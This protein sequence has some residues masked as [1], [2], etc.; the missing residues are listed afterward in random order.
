MTL[1]SRD[2]LRRLGVGE[3]IAAICKDTGWTRPQF[4]AWW[5][6]ECRRRLPTVEGTASSRGLARPVRICRD[7]WGVPHVEAHDDADLFFGFG[8]ATAQDRLFQLDF[9]RRKALGRLAEILGPE[10]VE[11]DL[12]YRTIGLPRIA[13]AEWEALPQEVRK[14]LDSYTAGVNAYISAAADRLPIEFDLLDY[15]PEPWSP[16]DSLAIAGEFRWYLT[17]RFPVIAIPEFVKRAVG[18]GPLYRAFLQGEAD[19]E[20]MMPPGSYTPGRKSGPQA[21]GGDEHGGSN[22]WV[23]APGLTTTGNAIVANDPHVP[24]AAVS[25]WHEIVLHGGSFHVGG[26]AYAGTPAV[27]IGRNPQVAWG[28]TNNICSLRD[29][30]ME[31]TDPQHPDH[32]LFDGRWEPAVKREEVIQVRDG[33]DVVKTICSSR[34]GPIVD[35]VL[36]GPAR[37]QGPVS[38]R[39]LGAEPCGWITAMLGMNRAKSTAEFRQATRPWLVPTFNLVYADAAGHIGHQCVG[40]IPRRRVV[41]RGYRPGWDPAHQWDGVLD[42]EDMPHQADP[43]RGFVVTANHRLAPDDYP[44]PLSGT[45]SSGHRGRRIREQ[46]EAKPRWSEQDCRQLQLDV[47]SGRAAVCAGAVASILTG[48]DDPQLRAVADWFRGWSCEVSAD[49]HVS[50][51]FNVFFVHWC[52]AVM[53]ERLPANQVEFAIPNAGGLAAALLTEDPEGWFHRTNRLAAVRAAMRSALDELTRRLGPDMT[54]WKWGKLHVLI[55]KHFLSQRGDL[56]QLLDRSGGS[57]NGDGTTVCSTT[58]DANHATPLGASYRMVTDLG[59]QRHGMWTVS[60]PG[61]SGNPGSQHYG[62]QVE[63]WRAGQYHFL[64]V[65]AMPAT[66]ALL[67]L[68]PQ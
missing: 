43:Q 14:L 32:F 19:D 65:D 11:F 57:A 9:Q 50:T 31:K 1:S 51:I 5:H 45:W 60:I 59:E 67:T 38:L 61:S 7:D 21:G 46:I 23:L 40:R 20:S 36:P 18:D 44:H 52:R 49:C 33:A 25:I 68:Q 29:L 12:L 10:A 35:E 17:G 34:N 13:Q 8:Y 16:T 63:L 58:S 54:E 42:F 4:D 64:A 39:W 55:Q 62:D 47:R 22:N 48:A 2:L 3:S 24:F 66:G 53:A 26:V 15:R 37:N 30:Y 41:E 56:G 6:D 27:M 28:I